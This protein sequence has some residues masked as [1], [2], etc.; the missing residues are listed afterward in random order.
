MAF[1][2]PHR[3]RPRRTARRR[4]GQQ[5]H[6]AFEER[7]RDNRVTPPPDAAAF[8]IDFPQFV[9]GLA[10]RDRR[11]AMFLSLGHAATEAA[12][13][14]GLSPG[15][16]TQLRQRWLRDWRLCQGDVPDAS[17][18]DEDGAGERQRC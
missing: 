4:N 15:R 9:A 6:D 13:K 7:L 8:R 16:V 14:F 17:E 11:M 1:S 2:C 12:A 5:L 10:E 3:R 18:H